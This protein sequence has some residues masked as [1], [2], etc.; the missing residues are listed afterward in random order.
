MASAFKAFKEAAS[1]RGSADDPEAAQEAEKYRLIVTA[2]PSYN[3]SKH[4]VVGVNTGESVPIENEYIRAKVKVRIRG[5]RGLPSRCPSSSPYFNDPWHTKDQY[6]VA[7]SFV[8]KQDIPSLDTVWGNDFDHPVRDRLPPG[9]NTAFKIVKEFIDPGLSCDAY[10]DE[11]WL[12]GPSLS[13]WFAFRVGEKVEEGEDF[14][15]PGEENVTVEGADGSGEAE[16]ERLGLPEN[17]EKRRKHFLDAK[18]RENFTFEKGR[19]YQADFFNPYLDFGNCALKLPG[20]SLN[21]IKYV[22]QK[23]HCL[24]YV[25]K[26]RNADDVFLNVNIALLWD[27]DLKEAKQAEKEG[28]DAL[29]VAIG[30][31]TSGIPKET[32]PHDSIQA[33]DSKQGPEDPKGKTGETN[34]S[35]SS[36]AEEENGIASRGDTRPTHIL[37]GNSYMANGQE[38]AIASEQQQNDITGSESA[39]RVD[40]QPDEISNALEATA[41][42]DRRSSLVSNLNH[43]SSGDKATGDSDHLGGIRETLQD[44]ATNDKRGS[45]A[46]VF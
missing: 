35:L 29:A 7:F 40:H 25:F 20:F 44:T 37:P 3:K 5:Y 36:S 4:K 2:G 27:K 43:A 15:E 46:G 10:A 12:Y 45:E 9:F 1:R 23:T 26:N 22:D 11:P 18:N 33:Q 30:G 17:N 16:R 13:C 41:T 38:P 34:S 31:S 14:P 42:E 19:C 39:E 32:S 24:R 8:P 6:S 21:V 28:D